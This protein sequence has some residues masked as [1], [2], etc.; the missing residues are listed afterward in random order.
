MA[1]RFVTRQN[2]DPNRTY[3]CDGNYVCNQ[4]LEKEDDEE[5]VIEGWTRGENGRG[6]VDDERRCAQIGG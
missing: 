5:P 1:P 3:H 6:T 4:I 2:L